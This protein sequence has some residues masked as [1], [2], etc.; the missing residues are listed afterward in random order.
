MTRQKHFW[1]RWFW[2]N[3]QKCFLYETYYHILW[4]DKFWRD[5]KCL[6]NI[7]VHVSMVLRTIM[8]KDKLLS[9]NWKVLLEGTYN[10]YPGGLL[11]FFSS[12]LSATLL[13]SSSLRF[14]PN[15]LAIFENI[16]HCD[17][18]HK[19]NESIYTHY[20]KQ[21]NNLNMYLAGMVGWILRKSQSKANQL[22]A[23]L[24]NGVAYRKWPIKRPGRLFTRARI[25]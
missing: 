24:K 14:G 25:T 3:V 4:Y 2:N 20:K 16:Q 6:H 5:K 23:G 1:I 15:V 10:F 19:D 17:I 13:L 7:V 21:F 9:W 18:F 22:E 8:L 11:L 12:S